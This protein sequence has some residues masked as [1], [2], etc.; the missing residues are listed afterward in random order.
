ME[1]FVMVAV[2]L[3]ATVLDNGTVGMLSPQPVRPVNFVLLSSLPR[4]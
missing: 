3:L 1:L 4:I 2:V